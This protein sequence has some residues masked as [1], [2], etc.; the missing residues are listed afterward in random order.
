[1]QD[2]RQAPDSIV[3]VRPASFSPNLQT[4]ASNS[5]Q[6]EAPA[7]LSTAQIAALAQREFDAT[8]DTL[9]TAG[10]EVCVLEDSVLPTKPDAVFPNNWFSTHANGTLALYPMRCEN[11]RCE[12]QLADQLIATLS[13]RWQLERTLD[14]SAQESEGSILEGTGVMC[15]DHP[16]STAFIGLSDRAEQALAE[17]ACAALSLRPHF[18]HTADK[19]GLPVYHTNVMLSVGSDFALLGAELISDDSERQALIAA[20]RALGK[21]VI[22][23]SSAQIENFSANAIELSDRDGQRY[24]ALSSRARASLNEIQRAQLKSR[25]TLLSCDLD[26][27]ELAG[28]SMRCMI[29]GIHLPKR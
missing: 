18:F 12:R 21:E 20:L 23:L 7:S 19:R 13:E 1:M 24:L 14:F 15:I 25:L 9:R 26:T 28:G 8:V 22:L 27:I 16:S 10:I 17:E 6:G 4:L 5:F 11:R 2:T 3:M 29:A